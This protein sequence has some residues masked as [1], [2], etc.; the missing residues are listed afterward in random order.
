MDALNFVI[1]NHG[2]HQL[3]FSQQANF[4]ERQ[5]EKIKI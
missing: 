1:K 4:T 3:Q 5:L 2:N